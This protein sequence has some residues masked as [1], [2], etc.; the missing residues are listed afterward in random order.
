LPKL[1]VVWLSS[2]SKR[3][4]RNSVVVSSQWLKRCS[5][6]WHLTHRSFQDSLFLK[7]RTAIVSIRCA[8]NTLLQ[9]AHDRR[10]GA[11]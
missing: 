9:L 1:I 6:H 3:V 5:Y 11:T 2:E 7:K 4:V 10:V 8:A